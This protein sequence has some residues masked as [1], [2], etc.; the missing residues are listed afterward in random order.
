M[1]LPRGLP[2]SSSAG[3]A[4]APQR[5]DTAGGDGEAELVLEATTPEAL[6]TYTLGE[7]RAP[8]RS[9]QGGAPLALLSAGR[10]GERRTCWPG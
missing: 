3:S 1:E 2:P 4:R 10:L 9:L 5:C 7:V 6:V 8:S